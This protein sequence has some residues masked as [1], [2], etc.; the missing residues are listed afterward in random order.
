MKH[1]SFPKIG[2]FRAV[3]SDIKHKARFSGLDENG[4]PV[5][6]NSKLPTLNFSGTV[7]LHGT[8]ASVCFDGENIWC[9]SREEIKESGHFGFVD[10]V[11]KNKA[12]F[13]GLFQQIIDENL[14][15]LGG[16]IAIYGE[17]AGPGIQKSVGISQIP[18]K[19]FFI[20]GSK[21]ATYAED[22]SNYWVDHSLLRTMNPRIT[23]IYE[24]PTYSM[25]IDFN[26]PKMVIN[27]LIDLTS[28]VERE[29]PVAKQLGF[30][31]MGEGIVWTGLLNG[32]PQRFKVKG[33]KHSVT[34]VKKLTS[35]DIEKLNTINDT[36]TY[37]VTPQRYQ[38]ALQETGVSLHRENTGALMKWL[39][40][41]IIS[42]E[43]DTLEGN[44]L[45]WKDV[46]SRVTNEYRTMFFQD[47]DNDL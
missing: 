45:V 22:E 34:K 26:N 19:S 44:G 4:D 46:A 3:I 9:Q 10:F 24:Y 35:V 42:E 31:G 15:N 38:Q 37:L 17:W 7:K 47:I 33:E 30:E 5:Y 23:N 14:F 36:L 6:N 8:N 28:E 13:Y 39:A 43:S 40:N 20:F 29:C 12:D 1:I 25:E 16:T 2:Q 41:D 27:D 18:E 11:N 32:I 21:V